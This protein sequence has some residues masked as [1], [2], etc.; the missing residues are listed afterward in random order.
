MAEQEEQKPK[1]DSPIW[2]RWAAARTAVRTTPP[3]TLEDASI[4][5]GASPE[6]D[7]V[8]QNIRRRQFL[9][10]GAGAAATAALFG[11][12]LWAE[13]RLTSGGRGSSSQPVSDQ[14]VVQWNEAALQ[15]IRDLQPAMPIAARALAIVHTCM[16]DAWA[17]YDPVA[18]GTRLGA[19]L[20]RPATE[21][22]QA[23]KAQA[24][25]YAA[26][27][28]LLALFPTEHARFRQIM[29][30][31]GYNPSDS[32]TKR[33]TP[34][35]IGNLASQAVLAFREH[36]GSN[37][38]GDLHPGSYSDYT[39]YQPPNTV[40]S[41][42]NPGLWQPLEIAGAG[43]G[44][45]A[46]KPQQFVCAQWAGVTPF[47]MNNA[48]QFVPKSGPAPYPSHLYNEQARQILQYSAALTDESKVIAEYW[49]S[50]PNREEPPGHW[51]L[52]AQ[53]I[54][55]RDRH[56]LDQNVRMF[57]A[58][59]NALLDT[60]IACWACKR[61]YNSAY[62][63]TAIRYLFKGKQVRAWAGPG[64]GIQQFAGQYW[65]PYR[66]ADALT[67][68]FPEY[69]SEQSAFSAAAAQILRFFTGHD[70]LGTSYTWPAHSSQI[71][72]GVPATSIRLSWRT[73]SQAAN[74]AGLAGRYSG[75]HFTHS[76]LDG[77]TLGTRVAEQVWHKA[78]SYMRGSASV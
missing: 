73:L 24:I 4:E 29:L 5:Q 75:T 2:R 66:P 20:R 17:A 54:S 41:L 70:Q 52:F 34:T 57:F 21:H 71:E 39:K 55:Q 10:A 14:L 69:C 28:A 59:A 31:L 50:G 74:Q 56:T 13:E 44:S 1:A 15:A 16:F 32:S 33:S 76:D 62:P 51:C 25:S 45:L 60:S 77:R 46:P 37:Q 78:Q 47:A 43:Q 18:L 68:P 27:R 7:T 22:T 48:L 23:N 8:P 64:K 53:F 35:G 49:T 42:T 36:D 19:Q 30:N 11:A 67:P 3:S 12:G 26:Y 38:L 58:L 65:Q 61:V 9:I 40:T 6:Q 63:L 72:P